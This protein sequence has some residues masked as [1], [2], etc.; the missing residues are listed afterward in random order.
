MDYNSVHP[1]PEQLIKI[2]ALLR[3]FFKSLTEPLFTRA[4]YDTIVAAAGEYTKH[5]FTV[6]VTKNLAPAP[7]YTQYH[8]LRDF[9][10]RLVP[11]HYETAK[12]LVTV[13]SLW[14]RASPI[15]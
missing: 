1:T 9:L 15:I 14:M 11:A 13:C 4:F 5:T 8:I 3:Y 6:L 10:P 12:H 7:V 2:R